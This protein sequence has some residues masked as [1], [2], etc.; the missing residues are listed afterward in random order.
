MTWLDPGV[1]V[2]DRK[3]GG[4]SLICAKARPGNPKKEDSSIKPHKP[5]KEGKKTECKGNPVAAEGRE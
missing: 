2:C 4:K 1:K 3:A 5:E